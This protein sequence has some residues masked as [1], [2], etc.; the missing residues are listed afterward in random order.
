MILL[1]G[2]TSETALVAEG[3]AEKGYKVLVSCATNIKLDIGCHAGI[4]RRTGALDRE[5]I[6]T[7]IHS[8]KI[9]LVV[10]ATHPYAEKARASAREAA[11]QA[12]VPYLTYI[13]PE[14][15]YEGD[16]IVRVSDHVRGAQIAFSFGRPVLLTTGAKNLAVYADE[17][18]KTNIP[19]IA[20]V[21]PEASSIEISRGL[22]IL[23]DYIIAE[24]GPFSVRKNR[25]QIRRF[26]AGVLV[27]KDSGRAGGVTEKIEAARLEGCRVILVERPV[28]PGAKS[29]TDIK[30]LIMHIATTYPVNLYE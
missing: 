7:L 15:Q 5:G 23:E 17:A 4:T 24:R 9:A 3:L 19:L 12:G 13:R 27:T 25:E 18:K 22:G 1:L 2:G 10:D 30:A 20:R 11:K 21:L 8:E 14:G 29:F 6:I 16:E 26:S 28:M